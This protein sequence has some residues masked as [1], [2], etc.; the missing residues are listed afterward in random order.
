MTFKVG[1]DLQFQFAGLITEIAAGVGVH[2]APLFGGG[3]EHGD[4]EQVGFGG[5]V[6]GFLFGVPLHER[7]DIFP[8]GFGVNGIVGFGEFPAQVP[9]VA[10]AFGFVLFE[11]FEFDDEIEV[12]FHV[13]P[14]HEL[15]GD[16]FVGVSAAVAARFGLDADGTRCGYPFFHG[17]V[18]VVEADFGFNPHQTVGFKIGVVHF[19]PLAEELDVVG[20][21]QVG[22]HDDIGGCVSAA[23]EVG[24]TEKD[25][26]VLFEVPDGQVFDDDGFGGCFSAW[27]D[28]TVKGLSPS[29][30]VQP[31]KPV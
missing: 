30:T 6:D 24:Q 8:D 31:G 7:D 16:F 14:V 13:E 20:V 11:A 22:L 25:I 29:G 27:H 23:G 12:K 4:V 17:Q 21:F 9:G 26:A 1:K 15:D 5:E 18:E 28:V 3:A 10:K 2:H 19:F